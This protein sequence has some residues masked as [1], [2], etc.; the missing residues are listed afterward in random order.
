[1]W[2]FIDKKWLSLEIDQDLQPFTQV[3]I[4]AGETLSRMTDDHFVSGL[5]RVVCIEIH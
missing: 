1:M 2:D 5:H 4:V 3:L